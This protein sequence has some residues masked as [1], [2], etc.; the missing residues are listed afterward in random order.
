MDLNDEIKT[1]LIQTAQSL[2]GS[3][4]RIFMART[5]RALGP[6]GQRLAERELG[7]N[8]ATIRKGMR[9]LESGLT[10]LD[11]THLRGRKPVEARLPNLLDDIRDLVEAWRRQHA[12]CRSDA[13]APC[14]SIEEVR[15][16]LIEQKGYN[17]DDLPSIQ[18][19]AARLRA[20]GYRPRRSMR[21]LHLHRRRR[22][23]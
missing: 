1:E 8:R 5:V 6:G 9:E 4:R 19:I 23:Q 14:M 11:A 22:R 13:S 18:T 12:E 20:L 7:W 16:A 15:R 10:C 3:E 17:P 21:H 2:K